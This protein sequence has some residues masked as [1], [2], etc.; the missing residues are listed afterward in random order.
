MDLLIHGLLTD[1]RP[2]NSQFKSKSGAAPVRTE[3]ACET[4]RKTTSRTSDKSSCHQAAQ[5]IKHN[6][7]L[8]LESA[9]EIHRPTPLKLNNQHIMYIVSLSFLL[10]KIITQSKKKEEEHRQMLLCFSSDKSKTKWYVIYNSE[11]QRSWLM[12]FSDIRQSQ[13]RLFLLLPVPMLSYANHIRILASYRVY[14][15]VS[16]IDRL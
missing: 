8:K 6:F 4:R 15:H 10:W 16:G 12:Y 13:A 9:L 3:E 2:F 1:N 14:R 5:V 7:V 11:F